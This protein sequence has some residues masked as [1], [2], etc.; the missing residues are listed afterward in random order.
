MSKRLFV[1]DLIRKRDRGEKISMVTAYDF[2]F[3]SLFD[4]SDIDII[5]VGDSLG[6]VV[7][8]HET[9]LPVTMDQM[10]YH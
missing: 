5:L 4:Q 2:A 10:I 7:Q 1:P 8:G 9:T 6:T 3:A